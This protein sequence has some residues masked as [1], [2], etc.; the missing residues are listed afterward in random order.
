MKVRRMVSRGVFA[1]AGVLLGAG[2][3]FG[4]D[5]SIARVW[6]EALLDAIRLDRPRPPV[7]ARNLYH[8]SVAMYDAWAAY[9]A[10]A[11]QV[12]HHERATAKDVAAARRE[13]ISYAA[14][15]L[16][17][18]RFMGSVNAALILP[19]LDSQMTSLGYDISNTSTSGDTPAA[20]GNRIFQTVLNAGLADGS[21]ELA[22]YAANNGYTPSNPPLV[23]AFPG[24]QMTS[25]NNWQPL[26]FDYYVK[27]NGIIVGA[28]IQAFIGPHWGQ[29]TPFALTGPHPDGVYYNP[30]PPAMLGTATD[31]E[32]KSN[33]LQVIEYSSL[34]DPTNSETADFSPA[35]YGNNSLGAN[36]GHGYA[37]NPVTGQPYA[38]HVI[39]RA[40]FYRVL[41]EFWADGP[42][43][44]T[45]PGHWNT[46]ANYV[47]DQPST[48]KRIG[49]TGPIVDDLEWD[50]KI[51]LAVN[52]A[53]HDAAISAWGLKGHYDSVRPISAIRYM[54]GLGQCTDPKQMSYNPEGIPLVE[55][56][57]AV[58]G[59]DDVI[60]GG[61]FRHL[62]DLDKDGEVLND[63]VGEIAIR[64]WR[65]QPQDPDTQF[66]GV[67]W[68]LAS[69]WFPFQQSTFV[70]PPFAGYTSGH[71]T[72]SRSAAEV[73]AAFTG[74]PFFPGGLGYYEF[75][76][77][78][79]EFEY[80]PSVPVQIQFATYFDAADQAG[81]SR[82]YG[83]IHP[84]MDDIPGRIIGSRVGQDAWE[85]ARRYFEG[86]VSCPSDWNA[87]GAS[88]S[89]DFFDFLTDFFAADADFNRDRATNS[90]DFFDFL[91]A[92]FAGCP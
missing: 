89:Q 80:G 36:D 58:I 64:A 53:V 65:G 43:S 83:G 3:V 47:A 4:Q 86:R 21:N 48:V 55:N 76:V 79:L 68:I 54:C 1:A 60:P 27:Q 87:S 40:D 5:H 25:P 67:G 23:I 31:A 56:L 82:I 14:Y 57:T 52:G 41:A 50:V 34:L 75:P 91:T 92:F 71:S 6:D 30:G 51:Y 10:Q 84:R 33:H 46:I 32:F 69:K 45:P 35:S 85:F 20:L 61:R 77:G 9:D 15:R 19:A 29:V 62:V 74:T 78:H 72:F 70:T 88:N 66:G 63:H 44:E 59:P 38:P 11:D 16:V 28:A 39:P 73:M 37:V 49:G 42:N 90:Q 18:H 8:T 26:A 22:N 2:S 17:R 81:I 12:M 24:T 13:T 7:H